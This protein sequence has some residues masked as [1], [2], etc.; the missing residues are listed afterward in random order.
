[1]AATSRR[2]FLRLAGASALGVAL[3]GCSNGG[4]RL[5]APGSTTAP[6]PGSTTPTSATSTASPP[7][8]PDW[9]A[10]RNRLGGRLALPGSPGYRSA[11]TP[12]NLAVAD[13][14][15]AAIAT[16]ASPA[17]VQAC[18]DVVR[19]S[20]IPAAARSGGHSYAGYSTPNGGLV[21]DLG[22]MSDVQ[23]GAD[24]TAVIGAGARL[25]DVYTA[26]GNAGRCLPAGS[27][28]TVGISGLTLGGGIGVLT[29]KYGLT[30]DRLRSA[31]V[32]TGD[33]RLVTASEQS[34]PELFWALR[35]GGGGNAGV[36]TSFEFATAPAPDLTV[37]SM[38]FPAAAAAD[39]LGAWQEWIAAAPP[40]LWSNLGLTAG[41]SGCRVGGC[42][43]GSAGGLRPLLD[44]LSSRTGGR[45]TSK[46]VQ[47]KGYLETMRYFA[48]S[49]D[50][51]GFVASSRILSKPLS[52]PSQVVE[53]VRGHGGLD[54]LFDALGG[55]VS[56]LAPDAT[57]FPHRTAVASAQVYLGASR[58]SRQS[59]A[60]AVGEVQQGLVP[61]LGSGAYVNYI[62]PNQRDWSQAYY[63]ANLPRLQQV[64]RKYD[65]DAL[66]SFPQ[67]VTN[68]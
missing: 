62:D 63:G 32:V 11:S 55:A 35:G 45:A 6:P 8:P 1:M 17:D 40:E 48:G 49:S 14:Q 38:K 44:D 10:L 51:Q 39:V 36:V 53:L 23:V 7:Q 16:C 25:M 18:L 60:G 33:G 29:R 34:E 3:A 37:F 27:C 22:G 4:S 67:S 31:Q 59:A 15:P 61:L 64:A 50:K 46:S 66:L 26:L 43:V 56:Q 2:G 12:F 30:C 57:A 52:D 5:P 41:G 24:G 9:A 20:R 68:A 21:M 13:H 54:L 42:F 28:A 65:P 19:S 47:S 58:G